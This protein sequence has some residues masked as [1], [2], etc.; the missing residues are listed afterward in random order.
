MSTRVEKA[1]TTIILAARFGCVPATA[2]AGAQASQRV[3][4]VKRFGAIGDGTTYDDDAIDRAIAAA[5]D[6]GGGTVV[7][8]PGRYRSRTLH[9]RSHVTLRLD[10]GATLLAA[11]SGMDPA[12]PNPDYDKYQDYGHSHFQNALLWGDRITDFAVTGRGVIEGD[13]NLETSN[14]PP[15]GTADKA[16]SLTRCSRVRLSG[17]TFRH[18]G[19]FAVLM[20]GCRDVRIDG[21]TTVA[22]E[23][24]VRDGINLIN[25]R[26]VHVTRSR[27][28]AGDDA[29]VFKSDWALGQTYANGDVTVTDAKLSAACC[30]ALMFGSETCGDFTGYHFERISING[31]DKSGLGMVSMDGTVISD[32]HYK[33]ITMT[34][35]RSAIMQK[36]GTRRR[37]GGSPGVGRIEN[38]TY[39]NVTS[40][41]QSSS[42]FTA[43]LWG[44]AGTAN[45]IRNVTFT[46]VNLTVP[47]GSG[48]TGTG[49]PSNDPKDYNPKSI[50]TRPSYGWYIHNAHDIKFVDSSVQ[51]VKNDC[52]P[53]VIA[54]SG[55]GITF[56]HFTYERGSN[57][58]FDFGFQ[59]V[60]D[61]CVADSGSPRIN[62]SGGSTSGC[63]TPPPGGRVEAENATIS[64]GV[65][66]SNHA[67]FSGTGFVNY[68]NVTG[69][70]VEVQL[71][72]AQAGDATLTLRFAN[73]TTTD[74]PMDITVNGVVV[75]AG[76]SFPGTGAWT[77]W[78]SATLTVPLKA[79]ANTVRATATTA[80][81]GP[82]LDYAEV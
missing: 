48:C 18:G 50:G 74:R 77:T 27:I 45:R 71:N 24:D 25:T 58:S 75:S 80:N 63:S 4:D 1:L 73:G 57:S 22:D 38:I 21:V 69:S 23:D 81:G 56:Q 47:G 28:E 72:A 36:I 60:T 52:R 33:D 14:N 67:G 43:T 59:S 11:A 53:A 79:G 37:C 66:E 55:S 32:V 8:P 82:N 70:Y 30:N 51:F 26:D 17:V 6:A 13:R 65:V 61:Y 46:N 35:V 49:V 12:E 54:N 29:L 31:A 3:Y 5:G 20:N 42:N 7:L 68:D 2:H 62:S 44:E 76:H 15:A 39:E 78:Q 19:H 34:G 9:L 64:Q 41:G 16:L 10:E 40:S